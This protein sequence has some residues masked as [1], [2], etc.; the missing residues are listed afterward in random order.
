MISVAVALA[1]AAGSTTSAGAD[2]LGDRIAEYLCYPPSAERLAISGEERRRLRADPP[3]TGGYRDIQ[4][5]D[6][7]AWFEIRQDGT[8]RCRKPANSALTVHFCAEVTIR[9]GNLVRNRL[10]LC[11]LR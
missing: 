6:A 1:A 10:R 4:G 5:S 3:V 9:D 8:A 2:P 7:R 11:E